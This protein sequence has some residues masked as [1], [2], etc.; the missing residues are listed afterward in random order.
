LTAYIFNKVHL[1]YPMCMTIGEAGEKIFGRA[2]GK[3]FSVILGIYLFTLLGGYFNV[4]AFSVQQIFYEREMCLLEA[5]WISAAILF[6]F[7]QARTLHNLALLSGISFL[8]ITIAIITS[9]WHVLSG[10]V[11]CGAEAVPK[12]GFSS[13]SLGDRS[14]GNFWV[15]FGAFSQF[16]F[17]FAGQSIFLEMNAEMKEPRD[18]MKSV[19]LSY[20]IMILMYGTV[21]VAVYSACG[22]HSP[23]GKLTAIVP[24]GR[25]LRL[26]G[27][28][29]LIHMLISY[30]LS[31]TILTRHIFITT[32]WTKG[33]EES[34]S[35]R[36]VWNV[37]AL[38]IMAVS[39]VMA[40]EVP[41][42]NNLTTLV[43][44]IGIC[45][46]CF[47]FPCFMYYALGNTNTL[48]NVS[49]GLCIAFMVLQVI[50]GSIQDTYDII[51]DASAGSCNQLGS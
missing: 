6:F 18:F 36:L 22:D 28:V 19:N 49:C 3:V 23:L 11:A 33:I 47:I 31:S 35:G 46:L 50:C 45:P 10:D 12:P 37:V 21:C 2:A 8:T 13:F 20:T 44:D 34:I 41:T 17:A 27:I 16:T 4:L 30:T 42:F 15:L 40:I 48:M 5:A 38:S 9:L 1:K 39:L 51:T 14:S 7:V 32:G 26:V 29:M 24:E 25:S 43:N